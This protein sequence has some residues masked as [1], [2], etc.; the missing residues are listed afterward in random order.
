MTLDINPTSTSPIRPAPVE[1]A[2]SE[3]IDNGEEQNPDCFDG[4]T[5]SSKPFPQHLVSLG[6]TSFQSQQQVQEQQDQPQVA[7]APSP[8][9]AGG[10]YQS[11][12]NN[13]LSTY[14]FS[15]SSLPLAPA[16]SGPVNAPSTIPTTQ[17]QPFNFPL[18]ESKGLTLDQLGGN[19]AVR[20]DL[21]G[22]V[23][24]VANHQPPPFSSY[25][26]AGNTGT[27]KTTLVRGLAGELYPLGVSTLEADPS[28]FN[29][30]APNKLK[31][32]F[33]DAS[34]LA[35]KSPAKTAVI[36]FDNVDDI[37][38]IRS[39]DNTDAAIKSHD[40]LMTFVDQ[41]KAAAARK[42]I[43]LVVIGTTSRQDSM[44]L[45][46][47]KCF[48]RTLE[49]LGPGGPEDR[50]ADLKTILKQ[51][52]L[53]AD[54]SVLQ[55]LAR[56]TGG[57]NPADL[58]KIV[59]LAAKMQGGTQISKKAALDARLE[60]KFGPTQPVTSPDWMFK[61]SV[62]HEL[63]HAVIR[64]VF[65]DMAEREGHPDHHLGGIDAL[66][67]APRPGVTASVALTPSGNP[68]STFEYYFGEISS[69]LGG[70][71]AEYLFGNGHISAGPGNDIRN[72]TDL[73]KDAV[74]VKGMGASVGPINTQENGNK[75]TD[76]VDVHN[77]EKLMND[78]AERVAMTTVRF[79]QSFIS[80]FA[81]DMLKN[82]NDLSKLTVSG[83]DFLAQLTAW[84]HADPKREAGLL[85]LEAWINQQMQ[86][87][88]P[89][90]PEAF[91]PMT[92]TMVSV[93]AGSAGGP[94]FAPP[95]G[96]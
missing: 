73:L 62:S 96:S 15:Q 89:K 91:D 42:D 71:E 11:S 16:P 43:N 53:Q 80:D 48:E 86:S 6:G 95:A 8:P 54:D 37:T 94:S 93:Q 18:L 58:D 26:L 76:E 78:T 64:H 49:V 67:F 32:V 92:N 29:D 87:I 25:L 65:N 30:D 10:V 69:N 5:T 44:D 56:G 22:L 72:A 68:A 59:A 23:K 28:A 40:K 82:K 52:G 33:S 21:E 1:R 17:A 7:Q 4:E 79:Y 45:E 75:S 83:D 12:S 24:S 88:R 57:K 9:P 46:A 51:R 61:L 20:N 31:Q 77:D 35:E 34:A 38:P 63:G 27:G 47:N 13:P 3:V 70:R 66:S 60:V 50:V 74:E 2:F 90:P 19:P 81:S 55:D 85:N 36:L 41:A 14:T 39:H 84:E